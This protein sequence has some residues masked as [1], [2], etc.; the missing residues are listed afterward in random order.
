MVTQRTQGLY[1]LFLTSNDI[2]NRVAC[3]I[4]YLEN[5]NLTLE[6]GSLRKQLRNWSCP[7]L[8]RIDTYWS[9]ETQSSLGRSLGGYDV[10]ALQYHPERSEGAHSCNGGVLP[11]GNV[12]C[13]SEVPRRL[14]G[15]G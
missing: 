12:D 5:W 4:E 6:G 13:K 3:D 10:G 7:R 11:K 8:R 14:R 2:E 1:R 9:G 15:S